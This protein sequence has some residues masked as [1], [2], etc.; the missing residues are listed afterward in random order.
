MQ[1]AEDYVRFCCRWLLDACR[2]AGHC[3]EVSSQSQQPHA[4]HCVCTFKS[5][6]PAAGIFMHKVMHHGIC[7][8]ALV[9]VWWISGINGA[10]VSRGA[11]LQRSVT[12]MVSA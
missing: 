7:C 3:H 4:R 5:L 10:Y 8:P 2:W 12:G 9:Q 6:V 11:Y 1:C